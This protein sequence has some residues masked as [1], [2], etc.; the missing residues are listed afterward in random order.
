MVGFGSFFPVPTKFKPFNFERKHGRREGANCNYYSAIQ[1]FPQHLTSTSIL[2]FIFILS[3]LK[4]MFGM[5]G[6]FL[7][8]K[9][10]NKKVW[11][12]YFYIL[13]YKLLQTIFSIINKRVVHLSTFPLPN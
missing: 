4:L 10:I 13:F 12:D 11:N 3:H 2:L 6:W 7:I 5:L 1:Y 8:K 9:Y